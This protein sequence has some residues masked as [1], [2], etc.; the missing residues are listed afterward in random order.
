MTTVQYGRKM[1][2]LI[3][4]ITEQVGSSSNA[5]DLYFIL[6]EEEENRGGA[7]DSEEQ[8]NLMTELMVVGTSMVIT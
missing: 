2:L 1:F 6:V 7:D 8:M 5:C 4:I 3:R